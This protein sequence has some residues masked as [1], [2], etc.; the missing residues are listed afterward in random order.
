[1]SVL[2]TNRPKVKKSRAIALVTQVPNN[3]TSEH[4]SRH[5]RK[6]QSREHSD[7]SLETSG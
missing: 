2:P 3:L 5:L 7:S 4:L 6:H 1:M